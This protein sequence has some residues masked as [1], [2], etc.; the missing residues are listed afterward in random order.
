MISTLIDLLLRHRKLLLGG[1]LVLSL[2]FAAFA[3]QL[4]INFSFDAFY[5]K[6]DP[7]Y[8]Y[9]DVYQEQF[10]ETQNFMISI[11]LKA[12]GDNIY[13]QEFLQQS[14]VLFG[15]LAE[16]YGI[17]SSII[18]TTY[19]QIKRR[20]T[21]FSAKP[22]LRFGSPQE[23]EASQKR[24]AKDPGPIGTFI[25][26]NETYLCGYFFLNDTLFDTPRRDEVTR[27]FD[28]ILAET[29]LEFMISGIPYI[30]TQYVDKIGN[31]LTLFLGISLLLIAGSLFAMY[32]NIWGTAVPMLVV[33]FSMIWTMG[34]MGMADQ[35]INLMTNLLI[36]IIFV[37]GM[38]DVIHLI[39]KYQFEIQQGKERMDALRVTLKEIGLATFLTSLTTS[40]GF[41]SLLISKM[42]PIR[43]FGMFAASGVFFTYLVSIIAVPFALAMLS[44]KV[45][46]R[47]NTLEGSPFWPRFLDKL[48][49]FTRT[50]SKEI[51]VGTFVVFAGC[52]FM[53]RQVSLD[54]YLL[55]DIGHEDPIRT[56][57]QFFEEEFFGLRPFEM[58][59]HAQPGHIMT[60]R[61]VL[62]EIEKI[63]NFLESYNPNGTGGSLFSP[64]LSPVSF[65]KQA[66][67]LQHFGRAKHEHIPDTQEEIDELFALA[68]LQAGEEVLSTFLSDD[69]QMSRLSSRLPDI[70]TD[71]F[72]S[73]QTALAAHM[74]VH[75]DTSLV[76]YRLTGH[77]YLTEHNLRYLRRSLMGGLMVAF[78]IIGA[79]MG[80]VFRSWRMLLISMLPNFIP[81][82]LTGG[83]MGLFGITLSPSTAIVFVIAF[84]IAVDDTIH[85]LTRFRLEIHRG[86]GLETAIYNTL[87]GTGKAMILT[88]IVL[89]GGFVLLLLSDFGGTFNTGFFTGLTI[90][91][92]L[93]SDLLLLPILLRAFYKAP[94]PEAQGS[95]G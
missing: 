81:L 70:G 1:V 29:D 54:T 59:L 87:Q 15:E 45:F 64:F 71:A 65:V 79:I 20:G 60:D 38:S 63:Q 11:A 74:A 25:S 24:I 92:A 46:Q 12:P 31:E 50:K 75:G 88:S 2:V 90:V 9:Y 27:E 18:A 14:D 40:V 8:Q 3:A 30:R 26:K 48:Y 86:N 32:R 6:D 16:V 44:P 95:V 61:E 77:A 80:V 17:D 21:G 93:V 78:I 83:V 43:S 4:R 68:E 41:A 5:P 91:F 69:R 85:F 62:L 55:E 66:N 10:M 67:K 19:P 13:D 94:K 35:P 34:T 58:G 57:M 23:V 53:L 37:V 56:S 49:Q 72:D 76:T 22:Y 47:S 39:T 33:M 51:V 7:E 52:F 28:E 42:P 84:G 82:L 36:P 73:L 89:L